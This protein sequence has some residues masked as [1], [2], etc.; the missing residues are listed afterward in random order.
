MSRFCP[1]VIEEK[2][3]FFNHFR[4]PVCHVMRFSYV[5]FEMEKLEWLAKTKPYC[6]PGAPACGLF[7]ATLM[8]FPVK[9]ALG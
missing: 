8:E 3:E 6:L 4:I 7:E 5:I 9:E 2:G 1:F